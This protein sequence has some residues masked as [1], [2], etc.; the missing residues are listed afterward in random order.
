MFSTQ[1]LPKVSSYWNQIIDSKTP[2]L[3]MG[4]MSRGLSELSS[5]IMLGWSYRNMCVG[6]CAEE[7]ELLLRNKKPG[8][9]LLRF[10]VKNPDCIVISFTI[11]SSSTTVMT[12]HSLILV[13]EEGFQFKSSSVV[14]GTLNDL[15]SD[16]E[17]LKH[18]FPDHVKSS[19]FSEP[20]VT[21]RAM[22]VF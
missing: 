1:V 10:S 17:A 20:E 19:A 18:L 12:Q 7:A 2:L 22:P 15:I 21:S 6:V 11:L 14:Y 3:I 4:I 9:F 5:C 16:C 13:S 8:T